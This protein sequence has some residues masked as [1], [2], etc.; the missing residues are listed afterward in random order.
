MM[1]R[2]YEIEFDQ[3]PLNSVSVTAASVFEQIADACP[4]PD[5]RGQRLLMIVPDGT[6]TAPVGMMFQAIFDHLGP[7]ASAIDVM[8]FLTSSSA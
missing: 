5:Y 6:R 8:R 2:S 7:V 1:K 4:T 3:H